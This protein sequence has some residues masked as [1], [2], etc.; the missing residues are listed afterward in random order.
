VL[1]GSYNFFRVVS[2]GVDTTYHMAFGLKF[3]LAL[4]VFAILFILS[5]PPSGDPQ[6]DAKRP[7]LVVG[8]LI[9]GLIILAVAAYLRTLH[10]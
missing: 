9:S 1:S 8:A 7:R 5:T 6:R 4:H 2:S 10:I 3:L